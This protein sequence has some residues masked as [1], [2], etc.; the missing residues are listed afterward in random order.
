M[1]QFWF[2]QK[3]VQP[4]WMRLGMISTTKLPCVPRKGVTLGEDLASQ[5]DRITLQFSWI[6]FAANCAR[7]GGR[8]REN[9]GIGNHSQPG[10]V[11][12]RANTRVLVL[13]RQLGLRSTT[14][15]GKRAQA[16]GR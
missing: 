11:I 15:P 5:R 2:F 16:A 10:D 3:P 8:S 13:Y 14:N 6:A 1:T 9:E 7:I 4:V 12:L